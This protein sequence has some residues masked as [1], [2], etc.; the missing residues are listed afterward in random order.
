[1]DRH[2]FRFRQKT[3]IRF[4]VPDLA[5]SVE[6]LPVTNSWVLAPFRVCLAA[7]KRMY[8]YSIGAI[9]SLYSRLFNRNFAVSFLLT[10]RLIS[11]TMRK[12][13]SKAMTKRNAFGCLQRA[14]GWCK[15]AVGGSKVLWLL[16]REFEPAFSRGRAA[17][18][19]LRK[20]HRVVGPG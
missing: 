17:P 11:C 13:E 8:R 18:R 20:C 2:V 10:S 6:S 12:I 7:V 14:V 4:R 15:T 16:S 19:R 9:I 5:P 1:M 3:H